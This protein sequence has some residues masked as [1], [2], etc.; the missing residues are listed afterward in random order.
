MRSISST[1]AKATDQATASALISTASLSRVSASSFFEFVDAGNPRFWRE[2]HGCGRHRPRE[3]AHAGF[4]DAGDV[5]HACGP[6]RALE[7]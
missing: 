5:Q 4:I 6:K 3:R 7:L 2:Y 1:S